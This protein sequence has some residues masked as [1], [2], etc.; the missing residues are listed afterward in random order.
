MVARSVSEGS[1]AYASG[2]H[3]IGSIE[4]LERHAL[5]DVVRFTRDGI[6]RWACRRVPHLA[7]TRITGVAGL[8]LL[9]V[10]ASAPFEAALGAYLWFFA[11]HRTRGLVVVA[12]AGRRFR[13]IVGDDAV[14]LQSLAERDFRGGWIDGAHGAFQ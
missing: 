12:N 5:R 13:A 3:L 7:F 2:Y 1:F 6:G 10:N 4:I 14:C 8:G 11:V 9:A